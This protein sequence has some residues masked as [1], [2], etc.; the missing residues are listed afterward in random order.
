M[1]YLLPYLQWRESL[2]S[3]ISLTLNSF[4]TERFR[5]KSCSLMPTGRAAL[6]LLCQYLDLKRSDEIYITTTFGYPNVSSCVTSTVFNYCKPSRVLTDQTRAILVIHE[7]GV[8]HPG[9]LNLRILADQRHIPLIEDCAHTMDSWQD[10]TL[11]GTIGDYTILSFPKIFPVPFGGALL[12]KPIQYEPSRLQR[13]QVAIVS[14]LVTPH[15]P[16]LEAYSASRRKVFEQLTQQIGRLGLAPIYM[17]QDLIAPWFF[18][19][20]TPDAE[21]MMNV[22]TQAGIETGLWHGTQ[23]VV[24]PCHQY[25]NTD[26]L[27]RIVRAIKNGLE[28]TYV[29]ID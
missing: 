29:K 4:L 6:A 2:P 12:G 28:S 18:P 22:A 3:T 5:K 27:S 24:F 19:I 9:L 23:I 21:I 20:Q 13:E 10:D 11:M 25:L 16:F 15:L 17:V 7:F 14:D 8:P 1:I 26:H